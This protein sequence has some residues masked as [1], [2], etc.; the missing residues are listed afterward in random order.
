MTEPEHSPKG[1]S[2]A[3]RW[4]NCSGSS[5]LL[6]ALEFPHTDEPEWTALGIAAHEAAADCLRKK[7]DTWEIVGQKYHEIE[8]TQEMAGHVQTYLDYVRSETEPGATVMVEERIGAD[9]AKRPHP[10]FYGTV[11]YG[12]YGKTML[13]IVDLKYGE[14]IVVEPEDNIQMK[15][16]AYGVLYERRQRGVE[17]KTERKVVLAIVQPRA[18]HSEGAIREWETTAGDVLDW[19]DKVLIPKMEA[20]ELDNDFDAGSWC[21][22]CPAKLFCPLLT[23]LFGAAAKANPEAI[24]NLS[25]QRLSLE[26]KQREAVKFY[27]GALDAEVYR[28]NM[29]GNIVPDTKVVYMK[30]NRV[31]RDG[32]DLLFKE[33]F[34]QQAETDPKLK[35]PAEMEKISDD[36]KKLVKE[37]AFMPKGKLTIAPISD[38]R[39]AVPVEKVADTFAH[40]ITQETTNDD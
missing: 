27:M 9:P 16:Y 25:D 14:G 38:K 11:D 40:Y 29:T 26:Y 22:F 12:A 31:F 37:W 30:S 8:V 6:A 4:M 28:R 36:A 23:G 15:Y 17:I 20:T 3:E 35:S 21:R 32:A 24:P 2:S 39:P 19:G 13:R 10:S 18:Y 7:I 33:R 1:A 5:A 34:G